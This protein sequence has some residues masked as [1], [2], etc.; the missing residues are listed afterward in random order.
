MSGWEEWLEDEWYGAVVHFKLFGDLSTYCDCNGKSLTADRHRLTRQNSKSYRFL[1]L[2]SL[3]TSDASSMHLTGIRNPDSHYTTKHSN[4]LVFIMR[5][6]KESFCVQQG[7]VEAILYHLH[8]CQSYFAAGVLMHT[9]IGHYYWP[10]R[11]KDVNVYCTSCSSCQLIGPL[12]PSVGQM[13]ILHL[14]SLYMMGLDFVGRFPDT[15]RG[16]K[17]IIIGVDYFTRFLFA[18]AVKESQQYLS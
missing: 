8:D 2:Q 7:E 6:S 15:P 16:N 4:L 14:Q 13:A 12:K 1:H 3:D 11:V 17:Y 18:Q 9:I 10:P 5:N